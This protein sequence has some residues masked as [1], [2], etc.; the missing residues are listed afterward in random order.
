MSAR[1]TESSPEITVVRRTHSRNPN[2][3]IGVI[4]RPEPDAHALQSTSS[5]TPFY[6]W[7]PRQPRHRARGGLDHA[8]LLA[9]PAAYG[10]ARTLVLAATR[11]SA[12]PSSSPISSRRR[13]SSFRSRELV[14]A[15]KLDNTIWR[16]DFD[17]P[18]VHRAVLHLAAHGLLPKRPPGDSGTGA[19]RRSDAAPDAAPRRHSG[20]PAGILTA[21]ISPSRCRSRSTSTA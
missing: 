21:A 4:P 12:S 19:P 15:L 14:G 8:P 17:V 11:R 10:L 18:D 6:R 20:G 13:S 1:S 9:V 2:D 5:S 7:M 3:V 16:A